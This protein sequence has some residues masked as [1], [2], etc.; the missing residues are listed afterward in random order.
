M[1]TPTSTPPSL[2][3]KWNWNSAGTAPLL[4]VFLPLVSATSIL[5]FSFTF[6]LS[7]FCLASYTNDFGPVSVGIFIVRHS[8]HNENFASTT[9]L[10]LAPRMHF[11]LLRLQPHT[12]PPPSRENRALLRRRLAQRPASAGTRPHFGVWSED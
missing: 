4:L 10:L 7:R 11:L 9:T 6:F 12:P 2:P 3:P 5:S 8:N 1:P